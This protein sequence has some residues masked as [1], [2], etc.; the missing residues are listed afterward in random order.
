MPIE[1]PRHAPSGHQLLKIR[2]TLIV[3]RS[4]KTE[5]EPMKIQESHLTKI[6]LFGRVFHI[7]S[8]G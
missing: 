4:M 5:V 8:A 7:G 3:V 6:D 1:R 2:A